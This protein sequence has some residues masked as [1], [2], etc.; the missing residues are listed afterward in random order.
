MILSAKSNVSISKCYE[1]KKK[2]K[3]IMLIFTKY[4]F[5]PKAML[6]RF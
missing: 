5:L 6:D 3:F 2:N 4:L 1:I